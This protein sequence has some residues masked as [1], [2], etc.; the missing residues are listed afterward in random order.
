LSFRIAFRSNDEWLEIELVDSGDPAPPEVFQRKSRDT[1]PDLSA[2]EPGG[3]GVHLIYEVFDEVTFC[4]GPE[5]GNTV[6][7]RLR[8]PK[9]SGRLGLRDDV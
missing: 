5:V 3:L 1:P 6:T 8:R 4:S 9:H 7:M 2:L